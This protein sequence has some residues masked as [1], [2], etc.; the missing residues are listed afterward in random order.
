MICPRSKSCE[1]G[2]EASRLANHLEY[3]SFFSPHQNAHL[4]YPA[5][6]PHFLQSWSPNTSAMK[7]STLLVKQEPWYCSKIR[8]LILVRHA[9]TPFALNPYVISYKLRHKFM[10]PAFAGKSLHFLSSHPLIKGPRRIS[11][12]ARGFQSKNPELLIPKRTIPIMKIAPSR[13]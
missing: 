9:T 2:E 7:L 10:S 3:M 6:V 4:R 5:R 11:T 8:H 12:P 1:D 13:Q